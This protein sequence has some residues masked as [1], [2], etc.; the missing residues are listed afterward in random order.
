MI[1]AD[2]QN[3]PQN[4]EATKN[5]A[6]KYDIRLR[7]FKNIGSPK[8]VSKRLNGQYLRSYEQLSKKFDF[9]CGFKA[10]P[11]RINWIC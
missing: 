9:K 10:K 7:K 6:K 8:M 1:P 3:L 4:N 5:L 11:E 2:G